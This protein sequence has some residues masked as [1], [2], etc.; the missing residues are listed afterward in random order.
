MTDIK[1][2][3]AVRRF[4]SEE[5]RAEAVQLYLESDL[6]AQQVADK[7]GIVV[8]TLMRWVQEHRQRAYDLAGCGD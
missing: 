5:L 4:A 1:G 3:C 8:R 2:R 7:Y 6:T